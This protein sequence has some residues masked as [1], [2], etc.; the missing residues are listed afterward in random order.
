[1]PFDFFFFS[2]RQNLFFLFFNSSDYLL[3]NA[4]TYIQ[5][6]T[7]DKCL[8]WGERHNRVFEKIKACQAAALISIRCQNANHPGLRVRQ[9]ESRKDFHPF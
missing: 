5:G 3:C 6:E 4:V 1:M 7:C 8:L 2:P 9:G